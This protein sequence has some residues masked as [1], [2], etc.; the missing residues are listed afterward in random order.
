VVL[1][2]SYEPLYQNVAIYEVTGAPEFRLFDGGAVIT[3]RPTRMDIVQ[4][5][6]HWLGDAGM[7]AKDIN[8]ARYLLSVSFENLRGPDVLVFTDK[9]AA[10]TVHFVL[11][12]IKTKAVVFERTYDASLQA[13]MPGVTQEMVRSAVAN[14]VFGAALAAA[15]NDPQ[16]K[17]VAEYAIGA[18]AINAG[19]A[20]A[21]FG[22]VH[23]TLLWSWPEARLAAL[24]RAENGAEMGFVFGALGAYGA[25]QTAKLTDTKAGLFGGAAGAASGFFG[26]A[27]TGKQADTFDAPEMIGAFAGGRRRSQAV[28][29]MMLQGFDKFLSGLT[30]AKLIS[31]R[32]AVPC[33]TLNPN[34]GIAVLISTADSVAYGCKR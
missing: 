24:D 1:A 31:T 22:S 27:P 21:L 2:Q 28:T 32:E 33:D 34:G 9:H 23:D 19:V 30:E 25:E 4:H 18:T 20:G 8:H 7:L 3:T 13:R 6:Q 26:A 14:G 11:R 29:G 17:D 16:E 5:Y 12:D 10:A 15:V